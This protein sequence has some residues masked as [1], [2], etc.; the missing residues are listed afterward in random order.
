MVAKGATHVPTLINQIEDPN[1]HL[2]ES[3]RAILKVLTAS[4]KSLD[5][6]IAALDAEIVRRS[7]KDP[8]ARRLMSIP[9]VG[10]I[11]ATAIVALAPP[12]SKMGERTI[13]RL[14]I[15]GSS[16]AVRQACM[17]GAPEGA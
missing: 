7:K 5:E 13:C 11:T 3:A 9:G 2:P 8:T 10:P 12:T 1:C 16:A 14:L 4:L 15:I 17:R 6:N